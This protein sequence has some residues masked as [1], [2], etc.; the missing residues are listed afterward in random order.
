MKKTLV[1]LAAGIGS[2]YGG[3]IKQLAPVGP[4]GEIIID[5]SIHDAIKAGFN[6][7]IFII[8]HD[9]EADFREVLG[10]RI[11]ALCEPLGVEIHFAFQ[12]MNDVPIPV[13][14]GRT[15]P[16]GTGHAL[17]CCKD[18]I[19]EPFAV[20][21]A[22]DYY[23]KDGFAKAAAFL[24]KGRY[25][26]IAYVLKNTLSEHGGVTRG[27]CDVIGG[28][29]IG[30]D[31]T[32]NI[33]KT[34]RGIRVGDRAL[35]PSMLVS[36][37]F[38]C[39]PESFLRVLDTEFPKFLAGMSDPLKDEYLLPIIIDGLL[40]VGVS[41][42]VI[43]TNDAW[44]GVTYKEDRQSVVESFRRLYEAGV[45]A[46]DLDSDLRSPDKTSVLLNGK[47]I[48][49]TGSP[50]FIGGH[51]VLR[52]LEELRGGTVVSFD[53]MNAYYDPAL[54]EYRLRQI[55]QAAEHA[56]ARHVFIR[57]SIADKALVD[58]VFADYHP[59]V[60]VNLAA[61][62]GV[63]YS[64]DH[65]DV[66]MESNLVGFYNILEAC[67]RNPVEHLVF[68][69]SSSVYDSGRSADGLREDRPVSLD[70]A[71]KKSNELLAHSYSKLYNIPATG[72]R[73]FSVYGPA[74]RPDMFYYAAAER[75]VEGK[76]IQIHNFGESRRDFTFIDDVVE[77]MMRV[78]RGAPKK[79]LGTDGLPMAPYAVY[80]IG[81]GT[82]V[83]LLD[84][85]ST[86]QKELVRADLLPSDYDF[87]AHRELV[88]MQ[89]GD[90]AVTYADTAPLETD[91]A[92]RPKVDI[93]QGLKRFV[94]WY[95]DYH[96]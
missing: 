37:N 42:S 39:L 92:F 28:R 67:R 79:K 1:I 29:L 73:L 81:C 47:T 35:A 22:D 93:R 94:N 59:D 24:E 21:N 69:S 74:G 57:G 49:V 68:A 56:P 65:P 52:L 27:L 7:I 25:G 51:L 63:Q 76:T 14:T 32:K 86:L 17:L 77:S 71:T 80:D 62:D 19:H 46:D 82:P 16:W 83:R 9:I 91:Y 84:L 18:L 64:I 61:Q 6:K 13:P 50:G 34:P 48:L 2:R 90:V 45:Y 36:M 70:V 38:W 30:I 66:C 12:E 41:V 58:K 54:K 11:E 87:A 15:K 10:N 55:E 4:H 53:N 75:L 60:V 78:M 95:K 44:F 33:I 89:P 88:A 5:Y 40:K 96:Q 3:G 20:I 43:P 72:L 23:G 26:M 31:E 85:I 8:R